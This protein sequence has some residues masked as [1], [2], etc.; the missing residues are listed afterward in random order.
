MR[1]KPIILGLTLCIT[2]AQAHNI[3]I[4]FAEQKDIPNM[5]NLSSTVIE[6]YFKPTIR[7]GYPHC[8]AHNETLSNEFFEEADNAYQTALTQVA[9]GQGDDSCHILIASKD[10][11]PD[12]I[13]GLCLFKTE[14]DSIHID[15]L[16]VSQESRGKGIGKALLDHTVSMHPET[17]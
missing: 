3:S 4:R 9:N 5:L 2:F 13:L 12:K 8:F 10:K 14:N 11:S 16:I 17:H 1:L 15:Y 6:E 7:S